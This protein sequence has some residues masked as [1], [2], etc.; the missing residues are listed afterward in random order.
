MAK[1]LV[2]KNFI[3]LLLLII[4]FFPKIS[5]S[6]NHEWRELVAGDLADVYINDKSI[7]YSKKEEKIY[8][9]LL[10]D[11]KF[12]QIDKKKLNANTSQTQYMEIDC[13]TM[14]FKLLKQ[15]IYDKPMGKGKLLVNCEPMNTT[16][17]Y[18]PPGSWQYEYHDYLCKKM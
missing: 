10:Y 12:F 3:Y 8:Y 15:C 14:M 11:I 2:S 18:E 13:K 6:T 9:Y 4:I 16:W 7:K 5:M 17:Q 1:I